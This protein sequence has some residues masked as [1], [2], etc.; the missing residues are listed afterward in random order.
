MEAY[1]KMIREAKTSF[2]LKGNLNV[3]SMIKLPEIFKISGA[4]EDP[5]KLII[6]TSQALDDALTALIEMRKIE[7]NE[8]CNNLR[9]RLGLLQDLRLQLLEWAPMVVVNYQ[10]K[11]LKRIQEL[12]GGVDVDPNRIATEV[13]FFAD[14]ADVTEELERI[15]SHV[16]QFL[17]TL[18]SKESI[19]RRLDFLIQELNREINTVGSKAN[20]LKISQ[21]VITFKVELEKMREQIQNIE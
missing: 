14:K 21:T 11:L 20:D 3:Q 1:I 18:D 5:E 15:E 19:G 10:E 8:L 4:D 6:V 2:H 16:L 9:S 12:A 13:A 17:Q 7:G